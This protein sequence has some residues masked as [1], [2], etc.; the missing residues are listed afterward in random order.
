MKITSVINL[1]IEGGDMIE[2]IKAFFTKAGLLGGLFI[3][4]LLLPMGWPIIIL[5][6]AIAGIA[7]FIKTDG[8]S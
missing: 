8:L 7:A 3:V 6:M 2:I 4:L 1:E 5:I